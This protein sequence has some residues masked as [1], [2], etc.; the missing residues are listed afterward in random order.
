[1]K[2]KKLISVLVLALAAVFLAGG[3]WA[4][5]AWIVKDTNSG[6]TVKTDQIY[7]M[8]FGQD[9]AYFSESDV[10]TPENVISKQIRFSCSTS[11]TMQLVLE[12]DTWDAKCANYEWSIDGSSYTPFT[13]TAQTVYTSAEAETE[14]TV[15]L[16]VRMDDGLLSNHETLA[17]LSGFTFTFDLTLQEAAA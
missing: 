6:N 7:L 8:E 10:L 12:I 13:E 11:A 15:T 4:L 16:Y 2:S 17:T 3:T 9:A 5:A 1:M 14:A